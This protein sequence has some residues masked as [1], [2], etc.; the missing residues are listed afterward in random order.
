MQ[1]EVE[2]KHQVVL[3]EGRGVEDRLLGFGAK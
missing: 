2:Q 3:S 1:Y